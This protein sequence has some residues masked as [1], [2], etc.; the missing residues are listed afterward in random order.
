MW[1]G[2]QFEETPRWRV[3]DDRVE[4]EQGFFDQDGSLRRRAKGEI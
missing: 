2:F 4:G 1:L 3:D